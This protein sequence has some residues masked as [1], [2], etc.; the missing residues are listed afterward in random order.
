MAE[1][2]TGEVRISP[3]WETS[4]EEGV[5]LLIE[6]Y[7]LFDKLLEFSPIALPMDDE[8][9][10]EELKREEKEVIMDKVFS[11]LRVNPNNQ[12]PIRKYRINA[13]RTDD[14][15]IKISWYGEADVSVYETQRSGQ[16]MFLHEMDAPGLGEI[17]FVA[18]KDFEL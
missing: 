10:W 12:E 17:Y 4:I 6:N 11:K 16:D 14:S 13:P 3:E 7:K 1:K 15:K 5:D 9:K 8:R 2:E 18:P